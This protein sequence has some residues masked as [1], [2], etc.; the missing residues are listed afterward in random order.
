MPGSHLQES[1]ETLLMFGDV[2]VRNVTLQ[3][4]TEAEKPQ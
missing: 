3:E 2:S 4:T 1:P